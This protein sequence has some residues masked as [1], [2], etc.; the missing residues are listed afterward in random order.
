VPH[1]NSILAIGG[2][3]VYPGPAEIPDVSALPVNAPNSYLAPYGSNIPSNPQVNPNTVLK[4]A[5][6][7]L[8]AQGIQVLHTHEINVDSENDGDVTNIPYIKQHTNVSRYNTSMWLQK[9]SNGELLLQYSQ[10]ISLYF[11][12]A[13]GKYILFPHITANTLTKVK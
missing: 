10:D 2:V 12:Q 4:D 11:P 1:G 9:L 7:A 6:A 8:A 5:L 3:Q 13:K